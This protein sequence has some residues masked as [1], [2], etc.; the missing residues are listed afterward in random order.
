M[1]LKII[2]KKILLT[3][4]SLLGYLFFANILKKKCIWRILRYHSVSDGRRHETNVKTSDFHAQMAFLKSN[5]SLIS[6]N[7]GVEKIAAGEGFDRDYVTVTFDDG[8]MDNY[9]NAY[10]ILKKFSIPA[11]IFIISDYAGGLKLLPHDEKDR[12]E[13][14][15]LLNWEQ[16]KK[17]DACLI[18]IGSHTSSHFRMS[19][20]DDEIFSSEI[21]G[22]KRKIEQ[23]TGRVV[24]FIS[25]P[26][27][28]Y[29]DFSHEWGGYLGKA[30][31]AAGC[32]AAYGLNS[33]ASGLFKLNR[34]GVEG[35]DSLFTFKSK[36]NGALD[37]FMILSE[38]PFARKLKNM[39]NRMFGVVDY[40]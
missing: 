38:K 20:C 35:S 27:G 11:A 31:F 33:A 16:I 18:E 5:Y 21:V 2:F 6:I 13:Y 17:M 29:S 8:Y 10:P 24:K 39:L 4:L 36:L 32:L 7:E 9:T 37:P 22:S 1:R 23:N 30:G 25:Y 12:P 19:R 15:Y 3:I 34:I 40:K 14:N 26:F 28:T